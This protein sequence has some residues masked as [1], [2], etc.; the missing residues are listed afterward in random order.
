MKVAIC[1]CTYQRPSGLRRQLKAVAAAEKPPATEVVVVDNACQEIT[2]EIVFQ[3]FPKA[4]LIYEPQRG[5]SH[6]RNAG[7]YAAL[8]LGADLICT[9]DDDDEVKP[10]WL[11]ELLATQR[12]SEAD[13][14]LGSVIDTY[15]RLR[16]RARGSANALHSRRILERLGHPWVDPATALTGGADRAMFERIVAIGGSL[17]RSHKS[18]VQV[19]YNDHRMTAYGR[20]LHGIKFGYVACVVPTPNLA[21]LAQKPTPEETSIRWRLR[22]AGSTFIK[23][24]KRPW[25]RQRRD[26]FLMSF[27]RLVGVLLHRSNGKFD[28]YTSQTAERR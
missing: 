6:A 21:V 2:A 15:G 11:V 18:I 10:D 16:P 3:Q 23:Y 22:D 26:K 8:A 27:G 14:V 7:F 20:F 4:R 28:Y 19:H 25:K 12:L 1:I 17:A 9:I 24:A 13:L 5:I